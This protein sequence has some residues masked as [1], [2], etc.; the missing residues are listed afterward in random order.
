MFKENI[1]YKQYDLFGFESQLTKK[2]QKYFKKSTESSFFTEVFQKINEKDFSCLYANSDSR[3]NVPVNQLVGALILKHLN[4][5]TYSA[6]FNNLNFNTLSRYAIGITNAQEDVFSEASIFNFQNRVISHFNETGEDLINKVFISITTEHLNKYNVNTSVQRGD[7]FLVDSNV[8]EYSKLRLFIEVL[9]RLYR[10]LDQADEAS[11]QNPLAQYIKQS[12]GRYVFEIR[13]Q[14]IK[15]E[16]Q[17]ISSVYYLVKKIISQTKYID[18]EPYTNFIRVYEEYFYEKEDGRLEIK[19]SEESNTSNLKSPDDPEATF[20]AKYGQSHVGYSTHISETRHPE[21]KVELITDVVVAQNNKSDDKQLES[22]IEHM[23]ARMPD[24]TEYFVD[25]AYGNENV[26]KL[27]VKHNITLYQSAIKGRKSNTKLRISQ[28]DQLFQVSCAGGQIVIAEKVT[29]RYKAKFDNSICQNCPFAEKCSTRYKG[30]KRV[31]AY[32]VY[33]FN[34]KNILAH[35]R[36]Q[37]IE[38]LP[39]KRRTTR[40]NVEATVKE[41]KRGMKNKKVRVRKWIRVSM[42]MFLTA[43]SVN[44]RRIHLRIA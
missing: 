18:Q 43:L 6:L 33:Y 34:E 2:Q 1:A 26:D 35:Q 16:Y 21:N 14:D 24:W 37:N 42:H 41:M 22:R 4:N 31:K 11:L 44:L 5:W 8:I 20:N 17:Q 9:Q 30:G 15:P 12:S 29:T 7:S 27:N 40:S 23:K 19:P 39:K 25:G 28:L 36:F 13:K 10:I 32:R 38:K 3:P